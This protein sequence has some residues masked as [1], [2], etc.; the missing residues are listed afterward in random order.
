MPELVCEFYIASGQS[1]R[2]FPMLPFEMNLASVEIFHDPGGSP[3]IREI[4][5]TQGWN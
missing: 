4:S 1:F 3:R 2:W 5:M